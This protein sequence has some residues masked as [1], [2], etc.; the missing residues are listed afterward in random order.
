MTWFN[1]NNNLTQL[2][3]PQK[4]IRHNT[5]TTTANAIECGFA[6]IKFVMNAGTSQCYMKVNNSL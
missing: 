2:Y 3:S 1:R 4:I 5:V 6:I